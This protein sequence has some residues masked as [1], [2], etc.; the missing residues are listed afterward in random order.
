MAR[1]K[2]SREAA[3]VDYVAAR[4]D[5]L[6]RVA[7]AICGDWHHAEDLLQT[8]LVKLYV[9]WPRR[10]GWSSP[11][12][13]VRRILVRS[14]IDDHRRHW[15]R[16]EVT[17]LDGV[18]RAATP[19]HDTE[20]RD[21]LFAALDQLPAQQRVCVVLRYWLDLSVAETAQEMGIAEGSVKAHAA[22]GRDRLRELLGA[23]HPAGT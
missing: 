13:Y 5:H 11:D 15:R 3:Y 2:A 17:G 20:Q 14:F 8:A 22:R 19:A 9:A 7:F 12:A 23:E 4:Q 21:L 1:G 6:R 16:R 18:D 10:D